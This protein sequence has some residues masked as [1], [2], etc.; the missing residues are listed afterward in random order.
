MAAWIDENI[1]HEKTLPPQ[2]Q[3]QIISRSA[4]TNGFSIGSTSE[5]D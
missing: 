5:G 2:D 1:E 3:F 4:E